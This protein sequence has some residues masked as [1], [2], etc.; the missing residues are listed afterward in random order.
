[1]IKASQ[2]NL[3]CYMEKNVILV[4]KY[5]WRKIT[6]HWTS[7]RKS[8]IYR[9]CSI[10]MKTISVPATLRAHQTPKGSTYLHFDLSIFN[11]E[12]ARRLSNIDKDKRRAKLEFN[13]DGIKITLAGTGH[14]IGPRPN[15]QYSRLTIGKLIPTEIKERFSKQALA[16]GCYSERVKVILLPEEWGM[17]YLDF[18][19]ES[20]EN[21]ELAGALLN[22]AFDVRYITNNDPNKAEKGNGDLLIKT[23]DQNIIIEVTARTPSTNKSTI[24]KGVNGVHGEKWVKISG[25]IFP[26]FLHS[27]INKCLNFVVIHKAWLKFDYVKWY[28]KNLKKFNCVILF[29]DFKKDWAE[30]ITEEIQY[31]LLRYREYST[32]SRNRNS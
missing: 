23:E 9:F 14:V 19:V 28:A 4:K 22:K 1:M 11:A 29:T 12:F 25:R 31:A 3:I 20:S 8:F 16:L 7:A 6:G 18:F 30:H 27:Q 2:E 17:N 13:T 26:V 5:R 32:H 15:H 21:K 10:N 24:K